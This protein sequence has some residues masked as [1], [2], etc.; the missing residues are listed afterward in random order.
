MSADAGSGA[1]A[2][3][4]PTRPVR[5]VEPFGQ[6]GGP[7]LVA[8]ALGDEL[9]RLW[10]QP[11]EVENY[12]GRGGTTAPA[13]VANAPADGYTLLV[14][15]S[16]HAY[17]AAAVTKL[18]YDPLRDF[19]AIAA[20]T[21]QPYAL[22]TGPATRITTLRQLIATARAQPG[23]LTFATTGIGTGTHL[24]IEELNLAAGISAKHM[25]AGS[26]EEISDVL[27]KAVRGESDYMMSPISIAGPHISTGDLVALGVTARRRS[28]LLTEVPTIS[29]AGVPGYDFPIWYG[30]W[31]PAATS[32]VIIDK[33]VTDIGTS[34]VRPDLRDRLTHEGADPITMT[35]REFARFVIAESERAAD[36][37]ERAASA[38]RT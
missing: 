18:P 8:R 5:L 30:L 27:A 31:A 32:Q 4:Y 25:P 22:V 7:D 13:L 3:G 6:G 28:P 21:S 12:P 14:H 38:T 23:E 33:L 1:P 2:H 26:D 29:E 9:S 19:I 10:A 36:I 34:L 20:L 37:L 17:S 15:T 24:G 11:V 16:A 35:Q